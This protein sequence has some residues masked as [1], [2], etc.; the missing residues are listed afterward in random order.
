MLSVC[1]TRPEHGA[2]KYSSRWR[3]VFQAKVATRPSALMPSWSSTVAMRRVRSAQ[4]P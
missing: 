2:A 4:A 1:S 3:E